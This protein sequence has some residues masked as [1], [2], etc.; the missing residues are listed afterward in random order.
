MNHIQAETLQTTRIGLVDMVRGIA[1]LAMTAFHF[2]WDL[3]MFG[4]IN[5]S[6]MFEP[7]PV[8]SARSIAGTFLFLV[9]FSLFLAH[10][11]G[12]RWRALVRRIAMVGGAAAIIS[13]ATAYATPDAFIFFGILHSITF[14]SIAGL[15]FLRLPW[16]LN[17][18]AGVFVLVSR[19]WLQTPLL[20]AP[21]WWW[22]GLS[23]II[24]ISNDYVPVFPFFG[25]V[26]LGI[27]AAGLLAQLDLTRRLAALKLQSAPVRFL[28][29]LGR[30][31]LAY[32]LLHQPVMLA[33]LYGFA[34]LSGRI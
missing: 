13:L 9:G 30:N 8:W 24:P 28:R 32:Y 10:S 27:A 34:K 25:M 33:L 3:G 16:W 21:I 18:I 23:K 5:P 20:D 14:A 29:F 6:V 26:L 31:S 7:F 11:N 15:F 22:S 1:L 12:V 4:F 2:S 17:A 19:P